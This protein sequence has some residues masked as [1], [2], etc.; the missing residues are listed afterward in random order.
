MI[1]SEFLI[2]DKST[3]LSKDS[4]YG[5]DM[6][7]NI[8]P[9][10]EL[11]DLNRGK[12]IYVDFWASW[13]APCR[14]EMKN[15][16]A[17]RGEFRGKDVVFV[18]LSLDRNRNEWVKASKEEGLDQVANNYILRNVDSSVFLKTIKLSSIPR[19]LLY[20]KH[21]TLVN[22]KAPPPGSEQTMHLITDYLSR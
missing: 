5:I 6:N 13:C 9:L 3:S 19:Y 2:S 22:K 15:A 14:Q 10:K 1:K 21:G 4:L 17:F 8:R 12:V 16:G 20:D 7:N 11:L 18:Y